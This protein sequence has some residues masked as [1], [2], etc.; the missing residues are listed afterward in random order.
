MFD[1]GVLYTLYRTH[2]AADEERV[3]ALDAGTG[4]TLWEHA[5]A[6]PLWK[7]PA[8]WGGL[9]PNATP[10]VVGHRLFAVGSNAMLLCLDKKTGTVLWS[11]DLVAEYGTP[12]PNKAEVGYSSSPIAHGPLVIVLVGR[13]DTADAARGQFVIA[14]DQAT[15][16]EVWKNL[17]FPHHCSS[18]IFVRYGGRD[19]LILYAM[20]GI[21]GIDPANGDLVW[22]Y[23][24][25][26]EPDA[27][28][29]P[30]PVFNGQDMIFFGGE[31]D[32]RVGTV[33]RLTQENNQVFPTVVWENSKVRAHTST[34][35]VIDGYLYG[36]D[37]RMLFCADMKTGKRIWAERGFPRATCVHADG[38]L[39]VLSEDGELTLATAT[40]DGLNVHDRHTITERYSLTPPTL[41]DQV[42]YVRDR[43]HIMAL[44]LSVAGND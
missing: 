5:N 16:R 28:P 2:P 18:P 6:A 13:K 1:G 4:R 12:F 29:I 44:D 22:S 14:F 40:P 42:L 31:R 19:Q 36:S 39:I 11:H 41:V 20:P 38:R 34:P 25:Q 3:V 27:Y 9:G 35:V 23:T 24:P 17:D 10:L 32:T 37:R 7:K 26:A 21:V 33:I 8:E 15:G 43:K 30:T